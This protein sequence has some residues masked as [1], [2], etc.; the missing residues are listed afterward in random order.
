MKKDELKCPY[1]GRKIGFF[2]TMN[3]KE[4]LEF[5]CS[6]CK[7]KSKIKVNKRLKTLIVALITITIAC[8]L[9]FSFIIRMLLIGS[10][11]ISLLFLGFY[12]FVPRLIVL[13]KE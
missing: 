2:E 9:I 3:I 7:N 11:I 10:L 4:N 1:C 13:K 8:F 5:Y 6:E 12:L